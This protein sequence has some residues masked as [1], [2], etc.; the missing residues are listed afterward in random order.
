MERRY[1]L[2]RFQGNA[3]RPQ[4]WLKRQLQLQAA[5]LVGHLDKIWPDVRD[6]KWIGGDQE[7]WERVPYWLDGFI[8]MAWLLNDQDM[9][10]RAKYYIDNILARQ[11]PDGWLCPC[12]AEERAQYDTW[13]ALLI[14][15]VLAQYADYT[16]DERIEQALY[17][18]FR[19]L[20]Q[21]LDR[22][23]LRN[24][25]ATRWYEGLIG[26]FWLY[27]RK[28]EGWMVALAEKLR[29][30]GF[31]FELL[32][33]K[34]RAAKPERVW[35]QHTHVVNMAMC[36]KQEA[37]SMLFDI[38]GD[39]Q[40]AER[41]YDKLMRCHGQAMGHFSGDE[42]LAGVSP[43]Q[44]TELCGVVEAMYSYEWLLAVTGAPQWGDRL[45][46]LAFN[47]LPATCSADMWSHQYDQQVNQIRCVK[48][49]LDKDKIVF[50]TNGPDSNRFGLEPN[51]GCCTANM[52]QGWPKFAASIFM[53][54][55]E[56]VAIC[57]LAPATLD[58][59]KA[60]KPLRVTLE[61][62]YPFRDEMKIVIE[63]PEE[64]ACPIDLRIPGYAEAA[65]VDGKPEAPGAFVRLGQCWKGKREI[66]LRL[67]MRQEMTDRPSGMRCL[68]RG[69]LLFS[70]PIEEE[71]IR[72]EN[73]RDAHPRIYPYCDYDILPLSAWNYGFCDT[74]GEVSFAPVADMPFDTRSAPI[75]ISLPMAQIPWREENLVA[76]PT[77]DSLAP[78]TPPQRMRLIPYG[79]TQLRMTEMPLLAE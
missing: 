55:A 47:T 33:E 53:E 42:C 18:A 12:P 10:A 35:T 78:I 67:T 40:F 1:A 57:A 8:P 49:P 68:W 41:A 6:S 5:G 20:N 43:V 58:C 25:G 62:D 11:Q 9:Q 34:F 77:P 71:W 7:G 44:G 65:S 59:E 26:L 79:C 39:G 19:Q 23:T 72:R 29:V 16:G 60:G 64:I 52:G 38:G 17:R 36:L 76:L 50:G 61:G 2:K 69:P 15:K 28:P 66:T 14:T 75:A 30:Q 63:A 13:A 4:G 56:G 24:W 74:Q 70:L 46:K 3:I 37:L 32:F 21:H 31:D 54:S 73:S 27:E 51:F 45:E 48:L 22:C